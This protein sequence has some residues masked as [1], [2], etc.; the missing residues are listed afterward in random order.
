MPPRWIRRFHDAP[1]AD[2]VMVC[3][4]HAGGSAGFYHPLSRALAP[5]TQVLA[6][7][8]PGRQ[9]RMAEPPLGDAGL[10]ADRVHR[11]LI[12]ETFAEEDRTGAPDFADGAL[13]GLRGR[14]LVLFGHSMGA[15]LAFEVA[16][17]LEAAG[18]PPA[19]LLASNRRAPSLPTHSAVHTYDDDGLIA[20]LGRV[21]GTE[22]A[23]F[24]S[25][26]LLRAALP[27]LRADY[28]AIET[29]PV[30][31]A[32]LSTPV[33]VLLA[34]DDPLT[35]L[36]QALAWR[37]HTTGPFTL[38]VLPGGHF[39]SGGW[40]PDLLSAVRTRLAGTKVAQRL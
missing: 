16:L 39:Y 22:S 25:G 33:A 21:G 11:A 32:R 29:H 1:D 2:T 14:R 9:D 13:P 35:D 18:T 8:Y 15:T 31:T 36:E 19:L 17:R 28:R 20:E 3:F 10:L 40:T 38:G 5:G 30:T 26:E 12:R 27:A 34:E 23:L 37:D 6:V 24:R 7:Q 4:P